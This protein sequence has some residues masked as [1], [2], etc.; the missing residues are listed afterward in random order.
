MAQA[1]NGEDMSAAVSTPFAGLP[2]RFAKGEVGGQSSVA[3]VKPLALRPV[4]LRPPSEIEPRHWL[5]G[6]ILIK[7][8]V[9]VL[10]APGGVGKTAW[11]LGS[12]LSLSMGR[13][14]IGEW[15]YQQQRVLCCNLEDPEEEFERRVAALR[16]HHQIPDREL[17]EQLFSI[18]GRD[19]RLLIAALED[20]RQTICYPDKTALTKLVKDQHIG[21][22][23]VDPFINCHELDENNNPHV[24]AAARAWAE[25]ANDADCAVLLVHHTRKGAIAGD[26]E[27][28]RGAI[29]LISA[30]RAA[31][32]LT[33]M[34]TQEADGF[35]ISAR[36]RRLHVRLD[37]AKVNNAPPS[38]KARWYRL[39]SVPLGN[40]RVGTPWHDGDN[41]QA[42]EQWEPPA[43]FQHS[44]AELNLALDAIAAGLGNGQLYSKRKSGVGGGARWCGN[45]V[46][47]ILGI[48]EGPVAKM[49]KEWFDSGLLKEH[50]YDDPVQRKSRSG[51][52]VD[53]AKRPG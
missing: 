20:D 28:G 34:T 14:L 8:F 48:E 44:P 3:Q 49:I 32:T 18:S 30:S 46:M 37:D 11:S 43:T 13:G 52:V 50:T 53:N 7:G 51:V 26:A 38:D 10:I 15:V 6:R 16:L 24:N 47:E 31:F 41:V 2:D 9:T 45:P 22:I 40:G 33:S 5:Y 35:G 19:R 42:I 39:A 36:D 4:R 27:G 25:I 12:A 23:I 21:V 1:G 17:E 29:A